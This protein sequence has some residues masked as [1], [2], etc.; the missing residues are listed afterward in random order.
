METEYSGDNN[1]NNNN[2]NCNNNNNNTNNNNNNEPTPMDQKKIMEFFEKLKEDGY[3]VIPS[4]L[5]DEECNSGIDGLWTWLE[6]LG[7]GI[8]RKEKSSWS[9]KK[10]IPNTKGIVVDLPVGQEQFVWDIR[11]N[12]KIVNI[13]STLWETKPEDMLVSFDRLCIM[14][15]PELNGSHS[16]VP[17][18][19]HSDQNPA[20]SGLCC[21]QGSVTL[22]EVGPNDGTLVVY[23]GSHRLHEK[24][25]KTHGCRTKSDFV[26]LPKGETWYQ[27]KGCEIVRVT[28]PKGSLIL[29]DSRTIHYTCAA[30]L[31]REIP[32]FRYVVYVCMTPRAWT[33]E[34]ICVQKTKVF[35][36]KKCTNHWPHEVST[37]GV[38]QEIVAQYKV[39]ST[40]AKLTP[41]G[42]RLAGY[43]T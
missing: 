12:P 16:P 4:I 25:F 1:N 10:W 36:E 3:C 39:S 23:K 21:V 28:A 8:K 29:W 19:A 42:R 18:W 26:L 27:E 32:R 17:V 35:E 41:L 20:K 13:F 34:D 40:L 9:D 31:P 14:V 30:K 5:S 24:Y 7:T 2:Y 38:R 11:Q 15:P 6:S 43:K 37:F 33:T 22:E